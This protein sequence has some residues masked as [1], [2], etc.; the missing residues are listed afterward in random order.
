MLTIPSNFSESMRDVY[1][2]E[3]EGWLGRLPEIVNECVE[4]WSLKVAEPFQPLS[5]NW[6][7]PATGSDGAPLVLKVGFP[8]PEI[9]CLKIDRKRLQLTVH[10]ITQ[11]YRL[12]RRQ[13]VGK[14]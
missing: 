1:G 2:A 8:C 6:V 11:V 14:G 7:A 4:R 12:I 10:P 5:Y 3:G 9:R 13:L